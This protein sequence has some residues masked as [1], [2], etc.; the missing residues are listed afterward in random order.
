[1]K[2]TNTA[3]MSPEQIAKMLI[4]QITPQP[5]QH[6]LN[7]IIELLKALEQEDIQEEDI[8][9][10]EDAAVML[11]KELAKDQKQPNDQAMEQLLLLFDKV[12]RKES[13]TP[14]IKTLQKEEKQKKSEATPTTKQSNSPQ[15]AQQQ[16]IESMPES[17][18]SMIQLIMD[19][20]KELLKRQQDA[21]KKSDEENAKTTSK[22]AQLIERVD[23][24]DKT[25]EK[26][27]KKFDQIDKNLDKFISLYELVIN[28]YNPFVESQEQENTKKTPKQQ[29]VILESPTTGKKLSAV[30]EVIGELAML[31]GEDYDTFKE[32]VFKWSQVHI[33]ENVAKQLQNTKNKKE[34]IAILS[35]HLHDE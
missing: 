16:R 19:E 20:M 1:M 35:D 23:Q 29:T 7:D 27:E 2:V 22:I 21:D 17:D 13:I 11:V 15:K 24:I 5:P 14:I 28:Q 18:D 34:L 3:D 12:A 32:Q 25:I 26:Y 31:S 4:E 8:P 6:V 33:N 9:Q 30:N 10:I